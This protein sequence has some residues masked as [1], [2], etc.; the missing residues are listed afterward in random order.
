MNGNDSQVLRHTRTRFDVCAGVI[1]SVDI[2]NVSYSHMFGVC[3]YQGIW[4][5]CSFSFFSLLI[6]FLWTYLVRAAAA[7]A[8][9]VVVVVVVVSAAAAASGF[10]VTCG[11]AS[12]GVE[13]ILV[14]LTN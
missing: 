11:D 9:V 10:T 2:A 7:A 4:L 5:C 13:A 12:I 6:A 14:T 3:H 8:A 1:I